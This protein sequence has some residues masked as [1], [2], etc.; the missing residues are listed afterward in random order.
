MRGMQFCAV[1]GAIAEQAAMKTNITPSLSLLF[2]KFS[3][4]LYLHKTFFA[5][6]LLATE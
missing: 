2:K 5:C 6:W 4:L 3:H 1:D